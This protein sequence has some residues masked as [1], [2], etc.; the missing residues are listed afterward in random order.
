MTSNSTPDKTLAQ[1]E[2]LLRKLNRELTR[3]EAGKS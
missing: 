3:A 2:E 1:V